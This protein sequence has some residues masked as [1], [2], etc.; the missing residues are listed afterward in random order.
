M[1]DGKIDQLRAEIARRA[2]HLKIVLIGALFGRATID[3]VVEDGRGQYLW[4]V[5]E[6]ELNPQPQELVAAEPLPGQKS[7]F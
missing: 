6:R 4:S 7:L 5:Y 2:P 3:A 1:D